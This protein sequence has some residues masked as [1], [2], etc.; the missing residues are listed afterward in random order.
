[1]YVVWGNVNFLFKRLTTTLLE[2]F[3]DISCTLLID[4]VGDVEMPQGP[5]IINISSPVRRFF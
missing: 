3:V 5:Y 1:M 4:P 2:S